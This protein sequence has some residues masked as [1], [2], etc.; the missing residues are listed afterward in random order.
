M[1]SRADYEKCFQHFNVLGCAVRSKDI[2][3]FVAQEDYT[4][5]P[6]W[7]GL[8][9]APEEDELER[10]LI[11]F[12]RDEPPDVQWSRTVFQGMTGPMVAAAEKPK[13]QAV[14]ASTGSDVFAIGSGEAGLEASI[15]LV[16]ATTNLRTV[17]ARVYAAAMGRNLARREAAGKWTVI[18]RDIPKD[19]RNRHELGFNDVAGFDEHHLYAVG[20]AGD[21]WYSDG[22]TWRRSAFPANHELTTVCCGED[23]NVYIGGVAGV[24]FMGRQDSWKQIHDGDMSLPFK[25]MVWFQDR[26]W[27]TS[28]Y[29]LWWIKEGDLMPADVPADVKVCSG[30]LSARDGVL[31][32]AGHGGAAFLESGTWH[33]I[34]NTFR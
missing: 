3:Y 14:V 33:V 15:P 21:V 2:F 20:G 12:M 6:R 32:V 16:G 13:A 26:V 28:D 22:A 19:R 31:V 1:I 34:F 4:R 18:S 17:G 7:K 29:G 11:S 24:T 10:R 9:E 8:G 27:C 23:G 30:Y 5:S 25:D